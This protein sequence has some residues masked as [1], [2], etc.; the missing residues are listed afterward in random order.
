M[1]VKMSLGW[2]EAGSVTS[3]SVV[4]GISKQTKTSL[5]SWSHQ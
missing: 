1:A 3:F 5:M 2:G 4:L